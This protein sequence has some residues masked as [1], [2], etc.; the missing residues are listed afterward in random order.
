MLISKG[1][2]RLLTVNIRKQV[3]WL[4]SGGNRAVG[5]LGRHVNLPGVCGELDVISPPMEEPLRA[6]LGCRAPV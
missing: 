5:G 4:V 2:L 1:M 3:G 6:R